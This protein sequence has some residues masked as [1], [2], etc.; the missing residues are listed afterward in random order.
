MNEQFTAFCNERHKIWEK[1]AAGEP[2]PWT[3][4][5]TL[6]NIRFCNVFRHLDRGSQDFLKLGATGSIDPAHALFRATLWMVFSREA[7]WRYLIQAAPDD[8]VDSWHTQEDLL[9][10]TRKMGLQLEAMKAIKK[11]T[12]GSVYGVC[13][14][15]FVGAKGGARPGALACATAAACEHAEEFAREGTL[16]DAAKVL[17]ALPWVGNFMAWQITVTAQW[18]SAF[19]FVDDEQALLGRGA[20]DGLQ[21]MFGGEGNEKDNFAAALDAVKRHGPT[22][23]GYGQMR[24]VDTEHALCEYTRYVALTTG[25]GR[26]VK[27]RKFVPGVGENPG[28]II[29][30]TATILKP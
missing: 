3:N 5:P 2:Q 10:I 18:T 17:I 22:L 14:L 26:S 29:P 24:A 20:G 30:Y 28:T 9:A 27:V 13:K 1:R 7:T 21:I 23:P 19:D 11:Q 6:S 16:H 4:D 25:T 15:A 12:F 8:D